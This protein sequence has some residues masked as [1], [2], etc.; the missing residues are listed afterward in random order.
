LDGL[1]IYNIHSD[2]L[3]E[4]EFVRWLQGAF[5][6][7][8]RLKQFETGLAEFP[9]EVFGALQDYLPTI[10]AKWDRDLPHARPARH[11][12]RGENGHSQ[13][14]VSTFPGSVRCTP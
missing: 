9:A 13:P 1:E 2:L 14:E 10:I 3:D 5:T 7:P 6:N 8:D 11:F 4:P 12:L